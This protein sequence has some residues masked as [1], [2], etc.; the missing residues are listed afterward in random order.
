MSNGLF[1]Y[2]IVKKHALKNAIEHKGKPD[3]K[4]VI[5]RVLGENPVLRSEF[6]KLRETVIEVIKEVSSMTPEQ[7]TAELQE[8]APELLEKKEERFGPPDL[9][10][11]EGKLV[12]RFAPNV[13]GP[14]HI[15]RT[16]IAIL[17]DY[18]VKKYKGTYILKFDDTDPKTPNKIPLNKDVYDWILEDLKWLG[19][20]ADTHFRASDNLEKYY[21][22]FEK[23]L[24]MDKAYVC[25]CNIEKWRNMK[26]KGIPC[27]C[28][29]IKKEENIDRWNKMLK[30][31]FKEGQAVA[32]IK[33][34]IKHKDPAERD[35]AAFRIV[36]APKH[37]F[38]KNMH[39]WPMMDFGNAIDDHENSVTFIL[40]GMDLAISERRQ[41]WIY[42]YF[43]WKYPKTMTVGH[44]GI[45]GEKFSTKEMVKGV[46]SKTY[47]GFDDPRL[48]TI[49]SYRK[50]GYAPESIYNFILSLS[51]SGTEIN[52]SEKNLISFSKAVF[53][54]KSRHYFFVQN[55]VKLVIDGVKV[56]FEKKLFIHPEFHERGVRTFKFDKSP[57]ELFI[58]KQDTESFE[59]DSTVRLKDLFNIEIEDISEK[60]IRAKLSSDQRLSPEINKIQWVPARQNIKA[61]LLLN[62]NRL[63]SGLAEKDAGSA[64]L[65]EVVQFERIG[66]AKLD[67]KETMTFV[68]CHK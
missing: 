54:P 31:K 46:S 44:I 42:S 30:H 52:F 53:E 43:N 68:F 10:D 27:P 12:M 22:Y 36:D 61:K 38:V 7:Q 62:N 49:S 63:V 40:R 25:T 26:A 17:N 16:R 41:K 51:I 65:D 28:R 11:I 34:D 19:V 9:E 35:W 48:P 5:S 56:P 3:E 29:A 4:A 58:Q 13:N 24:S 45:E 60:L 8:E 66:F 67:S 15:G 64:E 55:P 39:V 47:S 1:S 33:T 37:P 23:L 2:S 14:L 18:Y 59:V 50:R 21:S 57:V 32:R 20:K 6:K